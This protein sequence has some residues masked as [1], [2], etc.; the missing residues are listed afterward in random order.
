MRKF[1]QGKDKTL[2]LGPGQYNLDKI[3]AFPVYKFKPSSMFAS[4]V[5]RVNY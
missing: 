2:N 3:E 1:G 5:E 4:K